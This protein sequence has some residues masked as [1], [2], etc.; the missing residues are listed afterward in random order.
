[1]SELILYADGKTVFDNNNESNPAN[2]S[3]K[4]PELVHVFRRKNIK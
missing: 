3:I 1:M 2:I 4:C